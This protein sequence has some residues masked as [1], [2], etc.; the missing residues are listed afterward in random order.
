VAAQP[1]GLG[2]HPKREPQFLNSQFHS[3]NPSNGSRSLPQECSICRQN[4]NRTSVIERYRARYV[5]V[6]GGSLKPT[7]ADA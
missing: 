6:D 1:G 3:R 5:Q 4:A 2:N 7:A